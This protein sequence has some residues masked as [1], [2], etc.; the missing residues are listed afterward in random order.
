M[1]EEGLLSHIVLTAGVPKTAR[2]LTG[3]R[4]IVDILEFAGMVQEDDG[5]FRAAGES[6]FEEDPVRIPSAPTAKAPTAH[7][8]AR[9]TVHVALNVHIWVDAAKADL[10][11]LSEELRQFVSRLSE[12]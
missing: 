9:E 5:T 11:Q 3:A 10:G 6:A 2:Y 4:T 8:E 12:D 1:D 7:T